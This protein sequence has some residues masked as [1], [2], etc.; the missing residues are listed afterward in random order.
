MFLFPLLSFML[1]P[2]FRQCILGNQEMESDAEDEVNRTLPTPSCSAPI[3][4][5]LYFLL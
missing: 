1:H 2:R 3:M 5:A 4:L